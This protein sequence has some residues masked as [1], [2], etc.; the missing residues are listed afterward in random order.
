VSTSN[1][2]FAASGAA[3]TMTVDAVGGRSGTAILTLTVTDR[4]ACDSV[5][6]TV[7]FGGS[8]KDTMTGA[9]EDSLGGGSD[10]DRLTGHVGEDRLSDGSGHRRGKRH[11][12]RRGRH[13]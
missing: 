12:R 1:V 6:V 13:R 5:Q 2:N 3:L 11:H 8:G 7:R 10:N 4:Q 9:G